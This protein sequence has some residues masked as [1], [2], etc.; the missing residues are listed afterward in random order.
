M[1]TIPL[2]FDENRLEIRVAR[3]AHFQEFAK[4]RNALI[5]RVFEELVAHG[6]GRFEN[7]IQ[8]HGRGDAVLLFK[9]KND[10]RH[11]TSRVLAPE[12]R[13]VFAD[14]VD[15]AENLA[16]LTRFAFAIRLAL[17]S[18]RVPAHGCA[19][20]VREVDADDAS[21]RTK[22]RAHLLDDVK[23]IAFRA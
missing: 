21:A 14:P 15:F 4:E 6:F 16:V 1:L 19:L 13:V 18:E 10:S 12:R 22:L 9:P 7:L 11:Q 17:A 20:R 8:P 3:R 5:A 23:L 2:R